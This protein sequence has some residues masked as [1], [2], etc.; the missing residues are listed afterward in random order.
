MHS[1]TIGW[2]IGSFWS[3]HVS[4][5]WLHGFAP[6]IKY[7][8]TNSKQDDPKP[9]CTICHAWI[10]AGSDR[11]VVPMCLCGRFC[12]VLGQ[13]YIHTVFLQ[14]DFYTTFTFACMYRQDW[15][16]IMSSWAAPVLEKRE[17]SRENT[18]PILS[19]SFCVLS[20]LINF[21][22]PS[23][24]IISSFDYFISI[25]PT[26]DQTLS[27]FSSPFFYQVFMPLFLATPAIL[28][29]AFIILELHLIYCPTH[30]L[31]IH[32]ISYHVTV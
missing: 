12:N 8:V 17:S 14:A 11:W 5:E 32:S 6:F 4:F 22:Q 15:L 10:I 13:F 30:H 23:L 20:C 26:W 16:V 9:E 18:N 29:Y 24:S 21:R 27:T 2:S 31:I 25:A 19:K 3:V 28:W 7:I 1:L